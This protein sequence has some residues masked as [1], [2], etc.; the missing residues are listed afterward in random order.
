MRFL[1]RLFRRPPPQPALADELQ[2]VYRRM[3][4][5]LAELRRVA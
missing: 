3:S 5:E 4:E 1:R 2:L